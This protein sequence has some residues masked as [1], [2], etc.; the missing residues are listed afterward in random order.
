MIALEGCPYIVDLYPIKKGPEGN[1]YY[2]KTS[3]F[4]LIF[5]KYYNGGGLGEGLLAT[6]QPFPDDVISY[7]FRMAFKGLEKIHSYGMSHSD[8]KAQN[9]FI[10]HEN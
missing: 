3:R 8:I 4:Y 5:L 1:E 10:Y 7:L 9:M 6:L 2:V